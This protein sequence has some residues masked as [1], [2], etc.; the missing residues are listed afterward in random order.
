MA[1]VV[2]S[3]SVQ[4]VLV[5]IDHHE[6][7]APPQ[8]Y[9]RDDNSG[10]WIAK[11][12]FPPGS[13][14]LSGIN[15]V[16]QDLLYNTVSSYAGESS[17]MDDTPQHV[18]QNSTDDITN[19]ETSYKCVAE[20]ENSSADGIVVSDCSLQDLTKERLIDTG[21]VD[22]VVVKDDE[23]ELGNASIVEHAIE[24]TL[25]MFEVTISWLCLKL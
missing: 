15:P 16:K 14:L 1:Y 17:P 19:M 21:T 12:A 18:G 9:T 2:N 4:S 5:T 13:L 25:V 10:L 3:F 22:A 20:E 6:W 24:S 23:A 8:I 11:P 7:Y